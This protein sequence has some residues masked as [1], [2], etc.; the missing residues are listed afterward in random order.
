MGLIAKCVL[1][2]LA[3]Y[4]DTIA[5]QQNNTLTDTV[6]TH[7]HSQIYTYTY[8][9]TQTDYT[10]STCT[11]THSSI[12]L[13]P[14]HISQ[15][16]CAISE[17]WW[18]LNTNAST[19]ESLNSQRFIFYWRK[20]SYTNLNFL[21]YGISFTHKHIVQNNPIKDAQSQIMS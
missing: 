15:Y 16:Y 1:Y 20:K 13:L 14:T 10:S 21:N 9:H 5:R 11:Q 19:L 17:S 7:I 2:M 12:Y 4:T 3:R 18:Q 6:C 8:M